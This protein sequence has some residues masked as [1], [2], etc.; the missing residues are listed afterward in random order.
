MICDKRQKVFSCLIFIFQ[1][2]VFIKE[3]IES[4][5]KVIC[6]YRNK[7]TMNGADMYTTKKH[8][9]QCEF[10]CGLKRSRLGAISIEW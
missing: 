5:T 6:L 10:D 2:Y 7:K 1:V 3:D 8:Q 4:N 9:K